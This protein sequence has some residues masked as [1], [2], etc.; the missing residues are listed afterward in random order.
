MKLRFDGEPFGWLL[1]DILKK[2]EETGT[3]FRGYCD[4][5]ERPHQL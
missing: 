1:M 2:F 3:A 5:C 4:V